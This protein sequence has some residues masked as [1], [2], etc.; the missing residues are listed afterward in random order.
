MLKDPQILILDEATANLDPKTEAEVKDG[1][2]NLMQNRTV[3]EIAHSASAIKDA[4]YVIVLDKGRIAASGTPEEL[5]K[6][7]LF[8]QKLQQKA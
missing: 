1:L 8:Y 2:H 3:V 7:S 4:D 6:T 5:Q